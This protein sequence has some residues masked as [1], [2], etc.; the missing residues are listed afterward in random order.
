MIHCRSDG[1]F[2][3]PE[4]HIRVCHPCSAFIAKAEF[5]PF[6]P[7]TIFWCI[8]KS[9]PGWNSPL[10]TDLVNFYASINHIRVAMRAHDDTTLH[11]GW[12]HTWC[13]SRVSGLVL[14]PGFV[15]KN[16]VRVNFI[17]TMYV[18]SGLATK[19]FVRT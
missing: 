3:P 9:F 2:F 18:T 12:L 14:P 10:Q 1:S 6:K 17:P 5:P 4:F 13:G 7:T 11:P 8:H 16:N 19:L 15:P